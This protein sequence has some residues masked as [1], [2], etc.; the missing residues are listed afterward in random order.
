MAIRLH[1]KVL[2]DLGLIDPLE[3]YTTKFEK[4]P[5]IARIFT[6]LDVPR[7]KDNLAADKFVP[8]PNWRKVSE[9]G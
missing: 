2:D 8:R 3:W 7:L 6:H 4:R 1:P 5:G 9:K